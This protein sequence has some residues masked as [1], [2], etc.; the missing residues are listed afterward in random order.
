VPGWPPERTP[1]TI[2]APGW[3]VYIEGY[4][5]FSESC[6]GSEFALYR[7]HEGRERSDGSSE[8][9]WKQSILRKT[10]SHRFCASYRI[11]P[12]PIFL[13]KRVLCCLSSFLSLPVQ[14]YR[15][16]ADCRVRSEQSF[17]KQCLALE[18][19]PV[20]R[21]SIAASLNCNPEVGIGTVPLGHQTVLEDTDV[22]CFPHV[23]ET[24][25]SSSQL[26][27]TS[28]VSVCGLPSVALPR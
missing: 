1:G 24:V 5:T 18:L 4:C 9:T 19:Q 13:A 26:L 14:Y 11:S 15:A 2:L 21:A 17:H 7:S 10:L 20:W 16:R 27:S 6:L 12:S 23:P 22:C 3:H 28:M 8:I 25:I